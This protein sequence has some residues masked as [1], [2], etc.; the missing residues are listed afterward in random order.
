MY[1]RVSGNG[2]TS[3]KAGIIQLRHEE[4]CR[5]P[6]CFRLSQLFLC[7][8]FPSFQSGEM[9]SDVCYLLRFTRECCVV[10]WVVLL[11]GIWGLWD[12]ETPSCGVCGLCVNPALSVIF[13]FV[14]HRL[15]WVTVSQRDF[16]IAN[17]HRTFEA[18]WF[19]GVAQDLYDGGA[20]F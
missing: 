16:L 13:S 5:L 6:V 1:V 12:C 4:R 2:Q 10:S 20:W 15:N 7:A 17:N 3:L 18:D 8:L 11:V 9:H 19:S 14:P